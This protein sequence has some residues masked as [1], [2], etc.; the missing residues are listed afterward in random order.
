[1]L[2]EYAVFK[3][4]HVI[5]VALLIG[6]VTV[7][8]FWKTVADRTGDPRLVA[9]AQRLVTYTDWFFT[10]GGIVLIIVGGYGAAY[11]IGLDL[12]RT[13]WM[14]EGQL[15]FLA[16]GV[17]WLGLLVPA[18]MGQAR[19]AREFSRGAPVPR[20]YWRL[21]RRWLAWGIAA[22]VPPVAAT[23]VMVAK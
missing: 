9:F 12:F 20:S 10:L 16:S 3:T 18:Q 15:L 21:G 14:V 6:N 23:Y 11:A 13:S 22:T 17:I 7:T 8:A 5:G 19:Q 2:T 1:V 4:L